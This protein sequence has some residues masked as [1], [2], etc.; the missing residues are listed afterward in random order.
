MKRG[1]GFRCVPVGN[2]ADTVAEKERIRQGWVS[3]VQCSLLREMHRLG[4][5]FRHYPEVGWNWCVLVGAPVEPS[6]NLALVAAWCHA[7]IL[8]LHTGDCRPKVRA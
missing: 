4:A 1:K 3:V 5:D 8:G 2:W 7:A 6:D